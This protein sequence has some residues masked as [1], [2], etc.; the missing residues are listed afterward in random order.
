MGW[1]RVDMAVKDASR[2]GLRAGQ[3]RQGPFTGP[4]A[5]A[6]VCNGATHNKTGQLWEKIKWNITG[7]GDWQLCR[8][9]ERRGLGKLV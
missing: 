5:R 4:S 9:S 7:L 6:E 3:R 8:D 1:G 2:A